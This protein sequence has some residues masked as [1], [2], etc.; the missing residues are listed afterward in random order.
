[1]IKGANSTRLNRCKTTWQHK[2]ADNNLTFRMSSFENNIDRDQLASEDR[3]RT[4][5]GST[6]F[7]MQHMGQNINNSGIIQLNAGL[8]KKWKCFV[9]QV[10]G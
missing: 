9:Q 10:N 5:S 2:Q 7:S 8:L 4:Y 6:L 3:I 1:M